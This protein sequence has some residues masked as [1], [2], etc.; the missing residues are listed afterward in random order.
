LAHSLYCAELHY[1]CNP[2]LGLT[3]AQADANWLALVRASPTAE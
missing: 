2:D 1:A 3:A